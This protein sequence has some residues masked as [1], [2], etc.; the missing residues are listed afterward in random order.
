VDKEVACKKI[1]LCSDRC[2]IVDLGRCLDT[3]IAALIRQFF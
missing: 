1:L 2:V 3:N